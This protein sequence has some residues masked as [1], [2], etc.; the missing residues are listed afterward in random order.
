MKV[1]VTGATGLIGAWVARALAARGHAVRALLRPASDPAPLAGV[2]V[3]I[4]RGDV[5]DAASVRAALA[6]A[7][8]VVHLAGIPRIGADPEDLAGVN[9]AGTEIVLGAAREAGVARAIHTSSLS[10]AGGTRRPVVR[11]EDAP[12]NA[13]ALGIAYFLSKLRG[14]RIALAEAARGLPVVVLRP[15]VVLGPGDT[16]RSSASL[17]VA[18]AKRR[19][20]AVLA[21]GTSFCDVRDVAAGFAAALERGRPGEVYALGGHNLS[22]AEFSARAAA[23]AGVRPPVRV[24]YPVAW[25]LA[26]A[27]EVG[28]R[29]RGRRPPTNRDLARAGSLYTFVSSEK[30]A[31]ELGYRIRPLDEMIRDTLRDAIA[32][33]RLRAETAALRALAPAA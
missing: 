9:V 8:A 5:L 13:E 21:G 19:L 16:H 23:M 28:A 17:V 22:L 15:G 32:T 24:P 20:P 26:L 14:E 12:G 31:R 7:D 29:A 27:A 3:E 33:G 11:S 30:A 6:G 10:A 25:A 4:V 18:I 2:A 1:L